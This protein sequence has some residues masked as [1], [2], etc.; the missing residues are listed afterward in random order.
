MWEEEGLNRQL[1]Y[2]KF[3]NLKGF[4]KNRD[5]IKTIPCSRILLQ[6]QEHGG[7]LLNISQ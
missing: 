2:L 5:C 7:A 6:C 3:H 1:I 4:Q